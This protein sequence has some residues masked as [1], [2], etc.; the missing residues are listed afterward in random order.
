[1]FPPV[2]FFFWVGFSPPPPTPTG[3]L[4]WFSHCNTRDVQLFSSIVFTACTLI[5]SSGLFSS[6]ELKCCE[7]NLCDPYKVD[8]TTTTTVI[9]H[10][11]TM[12]TH[13]PDV[14]RPSTQPT[15]AVSV[16]AASFGPIL[17]AFVLNMFASF[18][19]SVPFFGFHFA[20]TRG[21][22]NFLLAI[23]IVFKEI[24]LF[25]RLLWF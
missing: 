2:P 4:A 12:T 20:Y 6:C 9:L 24:N 17:V 8:V 13:A 14:T 1:M 21:F 22:P 19:W 7:G 10:T 3:V 25:L 18:N 15:S 16:F 23:W 5:N 11:S